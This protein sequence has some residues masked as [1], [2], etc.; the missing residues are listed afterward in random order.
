MKHQDYTAPNPR[1]DAVNLSFFI[2]DE[3]KREISK[4]MLPALGM[5]KD[6]Q[7]HHR[8]GIDYQRIT[9][10]THD[11][12]HLSTA[13]LVPHAIA[14]QK[15][16]EDIYILKLCGNYN[17]YEESLDSYAEEA[18]QLQA[19]VIGFNY[20]G[21]GDSSGEATSFNDLKI[22][23]IAQVQRLLD[24]G[25]PAS[26]IVIHGLSMG[27]A[28]ATATAEYFRKKGVVLTLINERSFHST[29]AAA[30]GIIQHQIDERI[31]QGFV[32]SVP[33]FALNTGITL[34]LTAAG[35]AVDITQ[36]YLEHPVTKR[37]LLAVLPENYSG[38]KLGDGVIAD[39]ASL[40]VKAP[41]EA[42]LLDSKGSPSEIGHALSLNNLFSV[43][44]R[45]EK[46]GTE[47]VHDFIRESVRVHR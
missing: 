32:A 19:T 22:A 31:L 46:T 29:T 8:E 41:Q 43:N 33:S 12:N 42:I 3:R 36:A 16:E 6:E 27:G 10:T 2:G 21:V 35:W 18:R 15:K 20:P 47:V 28:V 30:A 7:F 34:G 5:K 40:R 23:A 37:L 14:G 17:C 11:Q 1:I 44:H 26:Q 9:V 38:G 13:V 25:I 39:E 24:Q 4:K 45:K